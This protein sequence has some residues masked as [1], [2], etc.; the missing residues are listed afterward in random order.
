MSNSLKDQICQ[1]TDTLAAQKRARASYDDLKAAAI[2]VLE[3]RQQAE[4]TFSGKVKTRIT[5]RSI[6]SLIR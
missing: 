2:I 6:A 4:Q 3:L 1:A 5:P